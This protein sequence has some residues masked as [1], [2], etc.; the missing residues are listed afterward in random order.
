MWYTYTVNDTVDA[1]QRAVSNY[2]I[3]NDLSP[4]AFTYNYQP[5]VVDA[6]GEPVPL[7]PT[8]RVTSYSDIAS[9]FDPTQQFDASLEAE[10]Y[11]VNA[12]YYGPLDYANGYASLRN[13]FHKLNTMDVIL[14]PI[15]NFA[16]GS[17]Y[18]NCLQWTN[19]V[20]FDFQNR[21]QIQ[22]VAAC[23][24]CMLLFSN[25]LVQRWLFTRSTHA[26][27]R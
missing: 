26:L 25:A 8:L 27:H 11:T 19:V 18:R 13:F 16:F 5:G 10:E 20:H 2:Y 7:Q 22:Y 23:R 14:P 24:A 9:L 15:N 17:L 4:D 3:L 1:V 21:G 6:S 12:S